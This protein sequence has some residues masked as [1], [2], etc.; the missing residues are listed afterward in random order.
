[1]QAIAAA[2]AGTDAI[3]QAEL[4][5]KI[6][7]SWRDQNRYAEA[8]QAYADA[9]RALGAPPSEPSPEW[10]RVWIQV[11]LERNTAYYWLGWVAES[12]QLRVSLQPA[13]ERHGAP[14]QRVVYLQSIT[15]IDFRRNRHVATAEMVGLCKETLAAQQEAGNHAG[16]PAAQFGVGF[17]LLWSGDPQGAMEP[18]QLALKRAEETG[19]VSLRARCLTYLTVAYRQCLHTEEARRHAARSLEA[20]TAARMPEYVATAR[21]NQGWIAWRA[22]DMDSARELARAALEL[23]R[24]LPS[25]HAS[26]PFQWLALWPLV[27]VAL[28]KEET[29]PA[30]DYAR[31]LLDPGQQRLP[32]ALS[33]VLEQAVDAWESGALQAARTLL[34]RSV[35]LAQEMRYL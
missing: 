4:Y 27:A 28:R 20:A 15:W 8:L 29:V 14:G 35:A 9:E 19:D 31:A 3:H 33:A 25:G 22:G 1:M 7:N 34:H 26:A 18:M 32:D 2:S 6:G 10:W 23:W 12:D 16:I 11:S 21:A 13:V 17:V 24:Q 30:V 5:R